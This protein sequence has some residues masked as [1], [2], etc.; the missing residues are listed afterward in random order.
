MEQVKAAFVKKKENLKQKY[1]LRN[2]FITSNTEIKLHCAV[3]MTACILYLYI[4]AGSEI[5]TDW[6]VQ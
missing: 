4:F 1:K 2:H 3:K 6:Y 5:S